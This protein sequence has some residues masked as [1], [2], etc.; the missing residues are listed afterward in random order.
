ME[1]PKLSLAAV[2][3]KDWEELCKFDDVPPRLMRVYVSV[4]PALLDP[5]V[6]A[7]EVRLYCDERIEELDGTGGAPQESKERSEMSNRWKELKLL[8]VD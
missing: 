5:Q 1:G 3:A 2:R 8:I 7:D 6:T 4:L